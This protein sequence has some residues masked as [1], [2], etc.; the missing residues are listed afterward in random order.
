[1]LHTVVEPVARLVHLTDAI[2]HAGPLL[3]AQAVHEAVTFLLHGADF[4]PKLLVLLAELLVVGAAA[5]CGLGHL[6]G[7]VADAVG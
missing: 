7:P 5:L 2:L 4:L 3:I 1:L 6:A